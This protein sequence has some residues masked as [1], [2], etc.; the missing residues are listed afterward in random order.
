MLTPDSIVF[1]RGQVDRRREEP[2]LRVSEVIPAAEAPFRLADQV[3][4]DLP[5][6]T[7]SEPVLLALK[8][9]LS[10]HPG[11]REV[12]LRFRT[13]DDLSAVIRCDRS[14]NVEPSV[15]FAGKAVELIGRSNVRLLSRTR[16]PI[17]FGAAGGRPSQ[18]APGP[19]NQQV[20]MAS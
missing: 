8:E 2:S 16:R 19:A 18:P 3:W 1:L 6:G 14:L 13:G 7:D 11:D 17:P 5:E 4:F 9:R 15:E 12:Y 10:E 20:P